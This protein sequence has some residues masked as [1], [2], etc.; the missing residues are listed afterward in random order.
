M[1]V[2]NSALRPV[3]PNRRRRVRHKIQTPAY[4]SFTAESKT[5]M[6]DLH[7]I[8]DISE[9][10]V[11]IQCHSPL[12]VKKNVNLCLDL[13]DCSDHIYTSGQ[14]VWS[15][16]AGRAG[17]HFSE[18]SLESLSR[19]REWLFVNVMAGVANGETE[20]AVPGPSQTNLPPRPN[21]SDT[22]AAVT[23]VQRQV[24]SLG[25]DL[26]Q[27]L[28]LIAERA[29]TLV[30]ASGAAIALAETDPNFMICR[31]S[32]GPDAPPV[33]ARLQVGSGFSGECVRTGT[34]LRCDDTEVDSRVDREGCRSPGI[35]SLLAAPVRAGEKSIGI[36]EVFSS[37]ANTFSDTDGQALQRL[38]ETVLAAINRAAR[39]EDLEPVSTAPVNRFLPSPGS[40]LFASAPEPENK[41]ETVGDSEKASSGI[42]LPRAH[43]ILLVCAAAAI[44]MVLGYNLA[45]LIQSKFQQR[46]QVRLETVLAS[47]QPPK[48]Y[49]A[50]P[51]AP[52]PEIQAGSFELMRQMAQNG[53]PVAENT[54]GLRYF[55]GDEKNAIVRDEKQAFRWFSRA[56]E[57]GSLAAQAKLGFLY[58]GGRGVSKDVN[59]AYFWTA[60]ARAR[61]DQEN[62]DLAAVL[63]SGMSREQASAIEQ[64]ADLW[65]R[66]HTPGKPPA[67][68]KNTVAQSN[69]Q[70]APL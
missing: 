3:S 31:A 42:S 8:V 52:T 36:L 44:A 57:H 23:A 62:K 27:A 63:A 16:A 10:G 33:G 41:I 60:I 15:N 38:A 48:S 25:A 43:L 69:P 6:L 58:W 49:P 17:L 14:V 35:R 39:S 53:D 55:Q 45:P 61:G 9:D 40:V 46:G 24:E 51:P 18:L 19:L 12:E 68:R 65:L 47:S 5:A 1:A 22:L 29:L 13:A 30:H 67:G 54:L 34:L 50:E 37:H 66:Q 64:R 21:Y 20:I 7:E 4:V 28:Q 32:S 70:P 11:A 2:M 56:A 59:Q 26:A